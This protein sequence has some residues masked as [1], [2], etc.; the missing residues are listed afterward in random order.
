MWQFIKYLTKNFNT[1]AEIAGEK[2]DLAKSLLKK[3]PSKK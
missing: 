3:A 1:I 2:A